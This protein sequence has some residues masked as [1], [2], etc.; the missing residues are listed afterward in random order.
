[1]EEVD[2]IIIHTCRQIGCNLDDDVSSLRE[3]STSLIIEAVVRCLRVI[4]HSINLSHQLPPGMSARYRL[5][6]DLANACVNLGWRGE[7]G[8]QTFLYSNDV[9]IRRILMFLIEKLPKETETISDEP[10]G[11]NALLKRKLS[12]ELSRCLNQPWLPPVCKKKGLRWDSKGT[13]QREGTVG[14]HSYRSEIL[15][16]PEG[17]GDINREIKKDLKDYYT[18][19]LPVV[20][21]QPSQSK[22]AAPSL[23]ERNAELVTAAQEWETEWNTLGLQSRLT[24][25][26][27]RARKA[28]RLKKRISAQIQESLKQSESNTSAVSDLLQVIGAPSEKRESG[29]GSRFTHAEKLQFAKD[30][31]KLASEM[32]LGEGPKV[33]SEEEIKQQQEEEA[34]SLREQLRELTSQLEKME[35]DM[36]NYKAGITELEEEQKDLEKQ[37][38][39]NQDLYKVKKKT[40]DLL[41]DAD[42]NIAKLQ[43]V[44]DASIQRLQSLH[45]QWE[46]HRTPLIAECEKLQQENDTQANESLKKVEDIRALREKMKEVAEETKGKEESYK[47]LVEDYKTLTRDLNRSA[48]TRRIMEIVGNIRK[49]KEDIEKILIETR[50]LQKEINQASGKLNRTFT[51]TDEM[52]FKDAKKD[53]SVRKAY[54]FLASLHESFDQLIKTVE[55]TGSIMREIRDLEDQVDKELG[56][57]TGA[58]LEKISSD[59][60]QMK[61]EN[62]GL[63][64]KVKGK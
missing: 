62:Q 2:K 52:I 41:P 40:M 29:K 39:A 9:E 15:T 34:N 51:A 22:H 13:W 43:S 10:L 31:D 46:E 54:K 30:D 36:K 12:A 8:Y 14:N 21:L 24:E 33:S 44:V 35:I 53:E 16:I 49:Q 42:N 47:Q 50:S 55:D 64:A 17:L 32:A 56:K 59:L 26:D 61:Q 38:E 25:K 3:F 4:D 23:L 48:Y 63:I 11:K 28:E 1:M 60:K 18:R 6:T 27:Y 5:G 7:I 45:K 57:K 37:Y 19:H 20:N 58:N